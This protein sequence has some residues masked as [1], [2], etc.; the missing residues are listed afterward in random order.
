MSLKHQLTQSTFES[1]LT[2]LEWIEGRASAP[3]GV[4]TQYCPK[5]VDRQPVSGV[6]D[7]RDKCCDG[8]TWL[9]WSGLGE[10]TKMAKLFEHYGIHPLTAEDI[11]N[12]ESRSKL[13]ESSESL[14]VV[15]KIPV[16]MEEVGVIEAVHFC[17]FWQG[18]TVLTFSEI[19]LKFL[20]DLDRRLDDP[21]RKIRSHGVDYL[22]WA[23]LDLVT[24]HSLRFVEH[25]S[26]RVEE[27][28][29]QLID[30]E[31]EIEM[32]TIH[33]IKNEVT[34]T[35]R[36]IRPCREIT[37]QLSSSDSVAMG[38]NT[39]RYFR[40]LHDHAAEAVEQIDHLRDKTASLREL[41]FTLMSHR[42]NG[43]MKVLT[44]LSAIFLPLTFLAGI[45]GM[46]FAH[47]PELGLR[48]AY[49]VFLVFLVSLAVVLAI[50][51]KKKGWL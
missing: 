24:D 21:K 50:Y 10:T 41:Y 17:L 6:A 30:D 29:D 13:E 42:M 12:C 19:P 46:N 4:L 33:E 7:L 20:T 26:D 28:E 35:Y 36:L 27:I 22:V 5:N 34:Q 38:E 43:V 51:F 14:F 44:S 40:D 8:I 49:P 31:V 47:M 48:W 1:I 39:A 9:N 45:Y 32:E 16:S 15:M 11:L 2:D 23:L 37:A 18:N 3:A 25:L